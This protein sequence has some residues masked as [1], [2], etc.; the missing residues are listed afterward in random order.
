MCCKARIQTDLIN[1]L[2]GTDKY[3]LHNVLQGMETDLIN[4]FQGTDTDRLH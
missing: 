1:M 3:R 4:M 2:Q